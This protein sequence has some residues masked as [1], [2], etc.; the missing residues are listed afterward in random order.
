MRPLRR[1][2]AFG[3]AM[4]AASVPFVPSVAQA[5]APE[6]PGA[7]VVL[8]KGDVTSWSLAI[9]GGAGVIDKSMPEEKKKEYFA[10]L[11]R[12]LSLGKGMLEKGASA[13]DTVEAVVRDL[14]NDPKFNAG[15]GAVFTHDGEH[16]MDA[17]IM[18]GSTL[19]CGSVAGLK[20]VKNPISLARLVMEKSKHV[21]FAGPGAEKF[22]DEMAGNPKIERAGPDYFFVQERYDQWQKAMKDEAAG[23]VPKKFGTVGAVALDIHGHLAAATST[24][25]LTD[26]RFGR[27]G[28][29]PV[30]GAGT[31]ADD[32]SC[33]VSA[34]GVGEQFIRHTVARTIAARVQFA[35]LSL[36]E[37]AKQTIGELAPGDGGVIA[38]GKDGRIALVFN[39]SGMFRGAADAS[40]RF[41]VAIWE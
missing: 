18:D 9:H 12:A 32:R 22:A 27:I 7:Q 17:A 28:D 4:F 34:T 31:Y 41:E 5:Q 2:G 10:A 14:E 26:K 35:G 40:G 37:A 8:T 20:T 3:L 16:E 15:K 33:A 23:S 38:V 13:V 36:E 6:V 1:F 19:G 11:E 39:S 25:G 29:V 24:G 30:I 21:F